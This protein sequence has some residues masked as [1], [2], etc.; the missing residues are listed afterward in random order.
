[1]KVIDITDRI[2]RKEKTERHFSVELR[3][4]FASAINDG[5]ARCEVIIN[6]DLMATIGDHITRDVQVFM[7][8]Y[9]DQ[10]RVMTSGKELIGA[11]GFFQS[12][13]FAV[14]AYSNFAA[15]K[16][17]KIKVYPQGY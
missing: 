2:E 7:V 16:I 10:D 14:S 1:M 9:D 8:I 3:A 12:Q 11:D 13:A 5:D 17:S 6:G 15:E 4:L